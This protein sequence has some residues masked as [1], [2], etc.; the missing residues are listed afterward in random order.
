MT[1]LKNKK[2]LKAPINQVAV[3]RLREIENELKGA[4]SI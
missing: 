2:L 4:L 3:V 1:K